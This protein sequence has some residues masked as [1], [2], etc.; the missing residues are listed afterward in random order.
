MNA[1][2]LNKRIQILIYK[3]FIDS[4]GYEQERWEPLIE[5]WA[6]VKNISGREVFKAGKEINTMTSIF[7]AR[8]NSLIMQNSTSQLM[9]S[10]EGQNYN[11]RH[12]NNFEMANKYIELT[13]E[14]IRDGS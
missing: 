2:N 9:V 1:G 6:N 8:Y 10:F 12:L 7:T 14:L 5:C 13:G 11:V 3:G 4:K